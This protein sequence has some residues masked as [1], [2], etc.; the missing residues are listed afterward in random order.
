MQ[1]REAMWWSLVLSAAGSSLVD[2]SA[3][4]SGPCWATMSVVGESWHG[5]ALGNVAGFFLVDFPAC[6]ALVRFGLLSG[7]VVGGPVLHL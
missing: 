1:S 2:G 6:A 7:L 3:V 4:V 5:G